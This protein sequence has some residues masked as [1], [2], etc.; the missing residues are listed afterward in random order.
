MQLESCRGCASI[1]SGKAQIARIVFDLRGVQARLLEMERD[2]MN[3][4]RV[5][6]FG[7]KHQVLS[8]KARLPQQFKCCSKVQRGERMYS[9]LP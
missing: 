3:V 5:L 9:C 1:L 7:Y 2:I 6:S 8:C 4:K